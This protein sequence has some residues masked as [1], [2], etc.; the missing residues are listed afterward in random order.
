[1]DDNTSNKMSET[2][3]EE[4]FYLKASIVMKDQIPGPGKIAV[5]CYSTGMFW[6]CPNPLDKQLVDKID[7]QYCGGEFIECKTY[8]VD[9]DEFKKRENWNQ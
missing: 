3:E 7:K 1:M 2:N 9:K 8:Y 6:I 5:K 4:Y